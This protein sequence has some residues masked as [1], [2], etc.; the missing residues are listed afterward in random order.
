MFISQVKSAFTPFG[1][2]TRSTAIIISVMYAVV[3]MLFWIKYPSELLP[4][5]TEVHLAYQE[6]LTKQ[7]LFLNFWGSFMTSLT[8]IGFMLGIGLPIAYLGTLPSLAPVAIILSK[9]RFVSLIGLPL[10]FMLV[11]GSGEHLKVGLITFSLGTYFLTSM[12]E[13]IDS[14]DS[15]EFDDART[16]RMKPWEMLYEVVILGKADQV[17]EVLRQVAAMAWMM[18]TTA[19]MQQES[20]G[21]IGV[22]LHYADKAK[23]LDRVLALQLLV[24]LI[25]FVQDYVIKLARDYT[26]RFATLSR[27]QR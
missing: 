15:D 5:P 1:K 21:G 10:V 17:F 7:D 19:E 13:V 2:T 20:G 27:E 8:A 3:I 23:M 26:C 16:L 14:V 18:L 25:G 6:L 24:V 22:L 9:L 12:M 4:R 11:L